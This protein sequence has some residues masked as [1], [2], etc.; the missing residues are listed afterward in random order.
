MTLSRGQLACDASP[1]ELVHQC[2][3][4]LLCSPLACKKESNQAEAAVTLQSH[5]TCA[6]LWL[7]LADANLKIKTPFIKQQGAIASFQRLL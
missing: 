3:Y 4:R 5:V 6:G 1:G 7:C 2:C